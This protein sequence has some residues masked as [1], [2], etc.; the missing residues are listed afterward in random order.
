MANAVVEDYVRE[1]AQHLNTINVLTNTAKE[2]GEN[3]KGDP[4]DDDL[5]VIKKCQTRIRKLDV[6]IQVLGE[7]MEMDDEVRD[8]LA[9]IKPGSVPI[10]PKYRSAG[11]LLYDCI[12]ATYGS[13]HSP[14]DQEAGK[15]WGLVMKRAA[16]HMGTSAA[17]TTPVAG[18][19]GG[20]YVVPVV[21]PVIDIFPQ[22]Q[23]LLT[24]LGKTPAPN[25]MTFI[26]PRIVDPDFKTGAAVQPLQKAELVSK[27]FDIKTDNVNLETVGG[28]L[29]V[30]QQL[31]S[32]QAGS[33][34]LIVRQLQR[35]V[36]WQGE[37]AGVLELQG[38][39]AEV[40]LAAGATPQEVLE[41]LYAGAVM[42]FD[43]TQ[44]LPTW[45]AY[46]VQ[47]WAMLGSLTDA[48]GRPLFPWLGAANALGTSDLGDFGLGPL[49][50]R[51]IISPAITDTSIWLGNELG[52]ECYSY[53]FPVLEAIE[54][55]VLG[56]Q[57]AVAE[58]LAFY[59]PT[60]TEADPNAVPPV[61][62]AGNGAVRVGP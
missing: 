37:A 46:G 62:Q 5:E 20:L 22:G 51:Q 32:L 41:A 11:E 39:T 23:P 38:S 52:M 18:G 7:D 31:M 58:A 2:R 49:G 57:V 12:H 27:K 17:E 3:G 53:P 1:R 28:Y 33:L 59:R 4:T 10:A 35:R 8:K 44:M 29:N 45:I 9:R 54:P 34:D 61:V 40:P 50:L 26:R 24:A 16:E 56:R 21:G 14:D 19:L 15:R 13:Q 30:S 43:A 42:V 47:G 36:A 25:S 60:T 55:S 6:L 48:A